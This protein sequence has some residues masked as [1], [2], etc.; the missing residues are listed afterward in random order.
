VNSHAVLDVVNC[1]RLVILHDFTS[2][3]EAQ[4]LHSGVPKLA[5]NGGLELFNA[6]IFFYFYLLFFLGSFHSHCNLL[7]LCNNFN[8]RVPHFGLRVATMSLRSGL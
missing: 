4:I 3:D 6:G 2:E 7:D 8:I 1:Q 5:R